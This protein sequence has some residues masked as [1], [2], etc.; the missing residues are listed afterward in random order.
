MAPYDDFAWFYNRYWS[1]EFHDLA[2]PILE[3]LWLPGVPAGSRLLDI[4]C[5]TG[6]LARLLTARGY[7]ITGIDASPAMIRYARENAPAAEFHVCDAARFHLPEEFDG[8]VAT[9]D[10]VNHILTADDL[11]AMFRNTA[12]ALKPGA[13]FV[14]DLLSEAAY[15][16]RWTESFSIVRD[17]HVLA[18]AGEGYDFRTR[19]AHCAIVMFRLLDGLWHRFDTVIRERCHH[20]EEVEGAL[21]DAGFG[22]ICRQQAGDLGM[23][24]QIGHGRDFWIAVK[25]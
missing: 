7:R 18:F 20:P 17:D 5:G 19:L 22:S 25:S 23:A 6:H 10:S 4:G 3:R 24:G 21:H 14:F 8:A 12:A 11:S 13:P 9:F 15:Q 2:F 1:E 16:T